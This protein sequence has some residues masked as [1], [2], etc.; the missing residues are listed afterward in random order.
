MG[1]PES[2]NG[3]FLFPR[4]DFGNDFVPSSRKR[5]QK[6][7]LGPPKLPEMGHPDR[8]KRVVGRR[9]PLTS[10][11]DKRRQVSKLGLKR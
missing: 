9:L 7:S 1:H 6:R 10:I 3:S 2:E 5:A 8:E 11:S 4:S